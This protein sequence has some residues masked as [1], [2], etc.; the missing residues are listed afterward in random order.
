VARNPKGDPN[1]AVAAVYK[2]QTTDKIGLTIYSDYGRLRIRRVRPEGLLGA[3]VLNTDDFVE[4]IN[5]LPC[6]EIGQS[7]ATTIIREAPDCVSI[8]VNR[9]DTTEVSIRET[10]TRLSSRRLSAETSDVPYATASEIGTIDLGATI[11]IEEQAKPHFISV[12]V[13]KP[14]IESK[15]GLSLRRS[16]E[17]NLEISH[18]RNGGILAS[19]PLAS[20]FKV[21]SID[22]QRCHDWS[23]QRALEYLKNIAGEVIIVAQN[24]NGDPGYV[25]AMAYKPSP[26]ATAGVSFSR[27]GV[28]S[29]HIGAISPTGIFRN[30]VLNAE[31]GVIAINNIPTRH[32][33]AYEA[34]EIVKNAIDSVTILS[35]PHQFTGIVLSHQSVSVSP[36]E[37]TQA[38]E[39]D[40]RQIIWCCLSVS[41]VVFILI[42]GI[43]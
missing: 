29:L 20:G 4:S 30:S 28:D 8:I 34:A 39:R 10:M 41:I 3:S 35:K 5:S 31:D 26:R 43:R 16:E 27:W 17:G 19:S 22:S 37:I 18:V 25:Q 1:A 38:S 7:L 42:I 21:L 6:G 32:M 40:K 36:L 14:T 9:T 33:T 15:L 24:P 23:S 13:S 11:S 12:K 2:P